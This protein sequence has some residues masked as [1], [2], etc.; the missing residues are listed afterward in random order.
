[1]VDRMVLEKDRVYELRTELADLN[2]N[3]L[4]K[5][6]GYQ[7]LFVQLGDMHLDKIEIN[8]DTTMEN[9][10]AW[11][12]ISMSIEIVKPI[13]GI[14]KLKGRTWH[15]QRKGPFYRR[16]YLFTNEEGV[17]VAQGA[18]FSVLLD[19]E[20][21]SVYRKK[22]APFYISEPHEEFTI[23]AKRNKRVKL[24]Y[25][26][27][28]ERKVYNSYIDCLGHVNNTR[29]GEFAYDILRDEEIEKLNR[30]KRIDI[31]FRSELRKGD[32]FSMHKAYEGDILHIRGENESKKDVAF[33]ITFTFN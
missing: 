30:L 25:T 6:N 31:Y 11:A 28:D 21:R 4:L 15:S 29:Y 14:V 9:N 22:E 27:A 16:E 23:D 8:V 20:T 18:S 2:E 3:N 12:F 33:D 17:V 5:P 24:D 32:V 10:L 13:E 1:M 7:K 26:K 19:M